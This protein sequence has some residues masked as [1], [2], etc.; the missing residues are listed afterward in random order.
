M[1]NNF[2]KNKTDL[3]IEAQ[4]FEDLKS[5]PGG[6]ILSLIEQNLD[7]DAKAIL[8]EKIFNSI[9]DAILV[10]VDDLVLTDLK[11]YADTGDSA[12]FYDTITYIIATEPYV[13]SEI[14][15]KVIRL[16][17]AAF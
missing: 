6:E 9:V 15:P 10:S 4:I 1:S 8:S 12:K 3:L 11:K 17:V 13:Q 2:T 16:E 5:M 7:D 14:I